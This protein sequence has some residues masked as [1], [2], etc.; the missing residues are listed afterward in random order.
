VIARIRAVGITKGCNGSGSWRSSSQRRMRASPTVLVGVLGSEAAPA[1]RVLACLLVFS[2]AGD[3]MPNGDEKGRLERA[4]PGK[5]LPDLNGSLSLSLS[6]TSRPTG[7][8]RPYL[9]P[10]AA[11]PAPRDHHQVK[12]KLAGA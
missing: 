5:V 9:Y 3:H 1:L 11:R 10:A 6:L 12:I 7:T 8:S 2:G 4:G